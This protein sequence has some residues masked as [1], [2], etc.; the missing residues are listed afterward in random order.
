MSDELE[1]LRT[2]KE[3]MELRA[4]IAALKAPWWKRASLIATVTA[5]VAAV[6]PITTAIQERY[7]NEREFVLQQAKQETELSLQQARQQSEL[8]LQ[9]SRQE[10][11]IRIAYLDRFEVPGKRLQTI[12]FLIATSTDQRLIAWAKEEQKYVESQLV[13]IEE[14]LAAVRKKIEEAPPAQIL[15]ELKQQHEELSRL[16]DMT[17]RKPPPATTTNTTK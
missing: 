15:S 1:Q 4:Q 2:Q 16:K 5:M 13:K 11:D 17:G 12:R 6:L 7:R 10:N 14:E 8:A 9:Q 3:V